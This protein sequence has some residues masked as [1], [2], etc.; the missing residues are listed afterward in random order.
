MYS[1]VLVIPNTHLYLYLYLSSIYSYIYVFIFLYPMLPSSPFLLLLSYHPSLSYSAFFII[2][3]SFLIPS[4]NEVSCP[5]PSLSIPKEKAGGRMT[6]WGSARGHFNKKL[7][8]CSTK[9]RT[10]NGSAPL[11]HQLSDIYSKKRRAFIP[12]CKKTPQIPSNP[13]LQPLI[14]NY[15]TCIT[16]N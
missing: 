14:L 11:R 12:I 4:Y 16:N 9:T 6:E 15:P 8:S 10:I 7:A 2:P 13:N 5:P 1:C 3:Y